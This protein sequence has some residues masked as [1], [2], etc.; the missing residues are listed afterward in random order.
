MRQLRLFLSTRGGL[1]ICQ[2]ERE[3]QTAQKQNKGH[4][5]FHNGKIIM[6]VI[7][8]SAALWSGLAFCNA[9]HRT[10]ETNRW[11][12]FGFKK[13][14]DSPTPHSGPS[15]SPLI[16]LTRRRKFLPGGKS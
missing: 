8:K 13:I 9:K 16:I 5:V 14:S 10:Y 7:T 12:E 15:L 3:G 11:S 6:N 4:S 2:R 1:R